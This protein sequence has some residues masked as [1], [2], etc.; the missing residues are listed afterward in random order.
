MPQ[1]KVEQGFYLLQTS[2]NQL[3]QTLEINFYDAYIE[4][5]DN[6]GDHNQVRVIEGQPSPDV[7]KKV[8]ASYKELEELELLPEEKRKI[9][10]LVLLDGM[11]KEP[12]QQNHQLTPDAIGFLFVY[13]IEQLAPKKKNPLLSIHDLTVGMGNLL[14]TV[15]TNLTLAEYQLTSTG[16]DIDD[17]LLSIAASTADWLNLPV[18]LYHQDSL[19]PLLLDPSDIAIGDLPIGYYGLEEKSNQ[20]RMQ[21][22]EGHS[23]AHHLLLEQSMKYV[24]ENG[25]GIFLLPSNFMTTEQADKLK[26]WIA[27]DVYLQGIIQL[28]SSL[29]KNEQSQKSIVIVQN[30]G[31]RSRQAKEILVTALPSLKDPQHLQLFFNQFQDWC[32]D[33]IIN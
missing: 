16:I 11:R 5:L 31:K 1:T 6:I 7:V 25:F 14:F 10:Q 21:V 28:P 26:E 20:F 17:T 27:E 2:I 30:K 4:T 33:N 12:I 15:L 24:K 9:T 22:E 8:E 29:F 32:E 23:Y 13:L 3:V 19:E 18:T